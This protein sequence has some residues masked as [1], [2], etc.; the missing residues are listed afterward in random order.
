MFG[1]KGCMRLSR[2]GMVLVM[3]WGVPV[4]E[5]GLCT[6]VRRNRFA[7]RRMSSVTC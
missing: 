6:G 4:P 2:I 5:C 3:C 1:E 7:D